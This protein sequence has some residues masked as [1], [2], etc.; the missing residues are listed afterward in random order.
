MKKSNELGVKVFATR[1]SATAT[2]K[3]LGVQKD[4]YDRFISKVN[5]K[6]S[7]DVP[8]AER[9][10]KQLEAAV[11]A[12]QKPA[13]KSAEKP[14]DMMQE[15]AAKGR[16][17]AAAAELVKKDK[18]PRVSVSSVARELILAGKSNTE[19]FAALQKQFKLDDKKKSYP[20]W[21]RAD[22]T[23]KGLLKKA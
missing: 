7:V 19:V 11:L 8:M 1:S 6:F 16:A 12:Q 4:E 18:A 9:H 20:A 3:K 21:Y 10:I 23:R 22:M 2:L 14:A 13:E 17:K 5:G 15:L